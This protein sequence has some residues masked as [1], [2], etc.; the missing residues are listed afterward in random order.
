LITVKITVM[1]F[2]KF[3]SDRVGWKSESCYLVCTTGHESLYATKRISARWANGSTGN[4]YDIKNNPGQAV[5]PGGSA[6]SVATPKSVTLEQDTKQVAITEFEEETGLHIVD[7]GAG[8]FQFQNAVKTVA[9]ATK[10]SFYHG[11]G[12]HAMIIW[13]NGVAD[14]NTVA[15]AINYN[16]H[17]DNT[18]YAESKPAPTGGYIRPDDELASVTVSAAGTNWAQVFGGQYQDWF[19]EIVHELNTV[20]A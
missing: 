10:V 14:L 15:A 16:I 11:S 6:R 9:T 4:A 13:I 1:P 5:F 7:V 19:L 18:H 17:A 2:W 20:D 3:I 8:Q 12:F